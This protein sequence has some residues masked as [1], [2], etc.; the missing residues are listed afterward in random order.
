[1][2]LLPLSAERD[3]EA[4]RSIFRSSRPTTFSAAASLAAAAA[5]TACWRPGLGGTN[6][7]PT[8]VGPCHGPVAELSP[9]PTSSA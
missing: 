6:S 2:P 7:V 9:S 3:S 1:M 4:S 5:R 8:G